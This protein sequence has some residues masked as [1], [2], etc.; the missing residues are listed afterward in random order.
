MNINIK[1]PGFA[2]AETKNK[3]SKKPKKSAIG[4]NI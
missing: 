3:T 4:I 1:A 2:I